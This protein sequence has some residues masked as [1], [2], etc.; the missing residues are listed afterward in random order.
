MAIVITINVQ[1]GGVG[2]STTAH[3]LASILTQKGY[4]VLV[5]DLD[6]QQNLSRFSG[7]PLTGFYTVYEALKGECTFKDA[8]HFKD[9]EDNK[10]CNYDVCT[11]H[12]KLEDA[13]KEFSE[14]YDVY[15]LTDVMKPIHD[16][17]DFIIIDT[18]PKLGIL[19]NMAL[20]AAD[21]V[22]VPVE[23]TAAGIQ[24]IGQLF[25]RIDR[26]TH[27]VRGSNKELK[28]AGMLL[29]KYSD[30]TVLERSIRKQLASMAEKTG[31]RIFDTTIRETVRIKEAQA[32]KQ[33]V[34]QH[35]PD[36]T[37]CIDYMNFTEELLKEVANHG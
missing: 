13:E 3:E 10:V 18:P 16:D 31:T 15:K 35:A 5:T 2:K 7:A 4:R 30:R 29:T 12:K 27:P 33:S 34:L 21:Y 20:T 1:K 6:P 37:A 26:I 36:C 17:Y 28:V 14:F 9:D 22:V 25:E 8:I 23:A 32:K 11:A 24:G 19:P